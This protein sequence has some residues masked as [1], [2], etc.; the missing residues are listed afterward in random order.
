VEA[1]PETASEKYVGGLL[2]ARRRAR[3]KTEKEADD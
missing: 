1:K 2:A 3:S